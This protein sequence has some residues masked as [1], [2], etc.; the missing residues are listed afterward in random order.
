MSNFYLRTFRPS[1]ST[2]ASC[3][4]VALAIVVTAT[5]LKIVDTLLYK[6]CHD[7]LRSY[8]TLS[9]FD[10]ASDKNRAIATKVLN[11]AYE[12]SRDPPERSRTIASIWNGRFLRGGKDK[13]ARERTWLSIV[14]RA[15]LDTG[16]SERATIDNV[17]KVFD[18][19]RRIRDSTRL[20]TKDV[21]LIERL[22]D[23]KIGLFGR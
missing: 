20:P 23:F 16:R 8:E 15:F 7:A 22:S 1:K 11:V 14:E 18:Q 19:R 13:S 17:S 5:L 2:I 12:S 21:A 6:Q 3:V 10:E 4:Y 9:R